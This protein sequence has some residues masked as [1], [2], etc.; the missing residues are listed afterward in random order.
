MKMKRNRKG[1]SKHSSDLMDASVHQWWPLPSPGTDLL[2]TSCTFHQTFTPQS[3]A[4]AQ[5]STIRD[6]SADGHTSQVRA[7]SVLLNQ[8]RQW[9]LHL[10]RFAQRRQPEQPVLPPG[11]PEAQ[12]DTGGQIQRR[13]GRNPLPRHPGPVHCTESHPNHGV[14]DRN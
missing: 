5:I 2:L 9:A 11:G 3:T 4:T 1:T 8:G 6:D 10:K 12:R 14:E 13:V 7:S